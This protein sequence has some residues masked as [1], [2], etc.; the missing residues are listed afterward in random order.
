LNNTQPSWSDEAYGEYDSTF[1]GH[2]PSSLQ[3]GPTDTPLFQMIQTAGLV[4]VSMLGVGRKIKSL[5]ADDTW[6]YMKFISHT[7]KKE[8]RITNVS[9]QRLQNDPSNASYAS[10]YRK[11]LKVYIYS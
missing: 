9:L 4:V 7:Y 10:S 11:G 2:D 5:V 1:A 3:Y 6:S 8:I